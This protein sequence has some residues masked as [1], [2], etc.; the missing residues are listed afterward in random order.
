MLRVSGPR[1]PYETRFTIFCQW[2]GERKEVVR[3]NTRTCSVNCR[4][5]LARFRSVCGFEPDEPPGHVT[6]TQALNALFMELLK[7]E[8]AR[9]ALV[10]VENGRAAE[11][12]ARAANGFTRAPAPKQKKR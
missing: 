8:R 4:M 11:L 2:C 1:G 3:E 5:H 7:A 12:S 9:R 6:P 10:R